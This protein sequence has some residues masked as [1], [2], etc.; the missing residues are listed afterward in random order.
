MAGRIKQ[1]GFTLVELAIALAIASTVAI[2]ASPSY[3][4]E[5]NDRRAN[6]TIQE[7]QTI[8]DAAR[9]YRVQ[10]G[11]W[12]DTG[13]CAN[14]MTVL[15][16]TTPPL[17]AGVGTVNKYNAPISTSC[18]AS[19]FSVDQNIV[20]DWDSVVANGLP[21]TQVT[22]AVAHTIR[23]TVG[24]P[25]SEPA[26]DDKLSRTAQANVELNTMRTDIRMANNSIT[27][28]N[29][30]DTVSVSASGQVTAGA[31]GVNGRAV[32]G[33]FIQLT[34]TA[35]EGTGCTTAGLASRTTSGQPLTCQGGIWVKS[36]SWNTG[37][38]SS[39]AGCGNYPKGSMGFDAAGK[40]YVCK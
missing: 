15:K 5:L 31:L 19:T 18:T 10:T 3:V 33:E 7:T 1:R 34:A 32:L 13:T 2:L 37:A 25:G 24:I 30:L 26:L 38:V 9:A 35:T 14:A 11:Q 36:V 39:G 27:G 20:K 23:S 21:A 16:G 4:E 28:A 6:V 12:P 40:L 8:L 22:D 29:N 17:L